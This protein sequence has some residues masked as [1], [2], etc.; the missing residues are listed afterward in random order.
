[1]VVPL[2]TLGPHDAVTTSQRNV[3]QINLVTFNGTILF[4]FDHL[5]PYK[6]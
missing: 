6:Y 4:F 5:I 3:G 2:N 1:M